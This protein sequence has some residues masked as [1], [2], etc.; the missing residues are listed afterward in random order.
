MISD[1][2]DVLTDDVMSGGCRTDP[3]VASPIHAGVVPLQLQ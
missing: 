3:G 2:V 1:P